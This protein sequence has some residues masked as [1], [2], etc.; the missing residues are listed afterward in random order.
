MVTGNDVRPP[1][2]A[3]GQGLSNDAARDLGLKPGVPVATSLVDAHAGGVGKDNNSSLWLCFFNNFT[4]FIF[5]KLWQLTNY[6]KYHTVA[7]AL[8]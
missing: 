5:I 4:I 7:Y 1:G 8:T 2:S 3:C 6:L